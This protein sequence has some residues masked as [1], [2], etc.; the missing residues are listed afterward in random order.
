MRR[1]GLTTEQITAVR[2]AFR[3]LYCEELPFNTALDRIEPL[4]GHVDV[5][6]ELIAFVRGSKRGINPMRGRLAA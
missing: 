2:Q 4:L 1:A 6:A 3:I 5:V